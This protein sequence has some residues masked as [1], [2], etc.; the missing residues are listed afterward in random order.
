MLV[1][2]AARQ[3]GTS[4]GGGGESGAAGRGATGYR[5]A[6]DWAALV[7]GETVV[8]LVLEPEENVFISGNCFLCKR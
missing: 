3:R 7:L 2:L 1:E 5:G 6:L 8:L 4:R